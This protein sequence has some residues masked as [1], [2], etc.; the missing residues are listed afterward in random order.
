MDENIIWR[1]T[2]NAQNLIDSYPPKLQNANK[3]VVYQIACPPGCSH[4][5]IITCSRWQPVTLPSHFTAS[6]SQTKLKEQNNY[7]Q[8]ETSSINNSVEWYIN[9]AHSDLFCAYGGSLFAQ[10]EMQVAEHPALASL[11]ESLLQNNI[12]PLTVE[13]GRPTPIL[14]RGVERR[15][16]ISTDSNS[17]QRRPLGLYGNNFARAT[18]EAIKKATKVLN[19]PTI[20]NIIASG[21]A[22]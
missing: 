13:A 22:C 4:K 2:L 3:K 21:G 14:I 11:R 8:Y 20:S 7:F 16:A 19:P 17:K 15:C 9:F 1:Q 10:D 12:E 5:S 6:G 18:P